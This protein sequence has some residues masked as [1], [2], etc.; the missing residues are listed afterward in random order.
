M[1]GNSMVESGDAL[2]FNN[3]YATQDDRADADANG[4]VDINDMAIFLDAYTAGVP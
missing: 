1:N 4:D 3:Y 2:L